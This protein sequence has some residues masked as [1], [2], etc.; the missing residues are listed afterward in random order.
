MTVLRRI[1][2]I[3]GIVL[4]AGCATHGSSSGGG[5]NLRNE[6]RSPATTPVQAGLTES[7]Q[8]AIDRLLTATRDLALL[9]LD[10][11]RIK[12]NAKQPV[13]NSR[14]EASLL[15]GVAAEAKRLQSDPSLFREYFQAQIDASKFVQFELFRQWR[16]AKVPSVT[17]TQT[18]A[19]VQAASDTHT[20]ALLAALA[21]VGPSLK[22]MGARPYI[23]TRARELLPTRSALSD[24]TREIA[25]AP[26]LARAAP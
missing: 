13:D 6:Q 1:A 24:P 15:Q 26:L 3:I 12:W 18:P 9:S 22:A 8:G 11:A 10:V 16:E 23:E 20:A 19:Q 2:A 4:V 17:L 5:P 14:A 7:Q 25:I 21:E